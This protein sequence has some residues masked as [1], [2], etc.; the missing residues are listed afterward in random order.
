MEVRAILMTWC[1]SHLA[2]K[3]GFHRGKRGDGASLLL[4]QQI[5]RIWAF[6]QSLRRTRDTKFGFAPET[7]DVIFPLV[8]E[9]AT[10]A[11]DG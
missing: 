4:C 1:L 6:Q 5:F 2:L 8:I 9:N 3:E 10:G 11:V 7:A